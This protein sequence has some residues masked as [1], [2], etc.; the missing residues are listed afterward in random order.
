MTCYNRKLTPRGSTMLALPVLIAAIALPPAIAAESPPPILQPEIVARLLDPPTCLQAD[1]LG[2]EWV[3]AAMPGIPAGQRRIDGSS[4]PG[5]GGRLR[6]QGSQRSW[7]K[8]R[9]S[10]ARVGLQYGEQMLKTADTSVSVAMETGYRL[11]GYADDGTAGTGPVLRGQFSWSQVLGPRTRL[12][13]TTR[14]EAGEHGAYLRNTLSLDVRLWPQWTL[15]AGVE[16]RRDS[17]VTSRNQTDA[18]VKLRYL[19]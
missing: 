13:Q 3:I 17:S 4:L 7:I 11:Q 10:N 19:F 18:T 15:G 1:C 2:G 6:L 8:A 12:A 5:G 9:G 16:T 14:L